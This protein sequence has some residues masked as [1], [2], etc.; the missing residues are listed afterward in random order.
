MNTTDPLTDSLPETCECAFQPDGLLHVVLG[1]DRWRSI[2]GLRLHRYETRYANASRYGSQSHHCPQ[3][4]AILARRARFPQQTNEELKGGVSR[5]PRKFRHP[6][7]NLQ[8][9]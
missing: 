5:N 6:N 4:V 8:V 3:C 9:S 1:R 2:C 7:F